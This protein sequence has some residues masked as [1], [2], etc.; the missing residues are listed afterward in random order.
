[1]FAAHPE[2]VPDY[3]KMA[4]FFGQDATYDA[5]FNQ[6]KK[7][8]REASN[9]RGGNSVPTTPSKRTAVKS[10]R[11]TKPGSAKK[12]SQD[13][14]TSAPSTPSKQ[15][16]KREIVDQK[17][18]PFTIVLDDDDDTVKCKD[19]EDIKDSDIKAWQEEPEFA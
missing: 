1:M 6:F 7:Y 15:T 4:V 18:P 11:V 9:M 2:L 3:R 12:K 13:G 8:R 5:I 14:M 19:E 16:A 17:P 10:G